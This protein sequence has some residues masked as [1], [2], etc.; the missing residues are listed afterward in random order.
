ML[1]LGMHVLSRLKSLR[2]GEVFCQGWDHHGMVCSGC[3]IVTKSLLQYGFKVTVITPSFLGR[4]RIGPA[5]LK[6]GS[7][8][9]S[10]GNVCWAYMPPLRSKFD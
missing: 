1:A 3:V 8:T 6:G 10:D 4:A 5:E 7:S 9:L 2:R